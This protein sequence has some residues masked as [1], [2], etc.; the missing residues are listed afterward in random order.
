MLAMLLIDY[1]EEPITP[2]LTD[3]DLADVADLPYDAE[4][5]QRNDLLQLCFHYAIGHVLRDCLGEQ[6]M[7]RPRRATLH[8]TSSPCEEGKRKGSTA[9]RSPAPTE[10]DLFSSLMSAAQVLVFCWQTC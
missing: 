4:Q 9:E 7:E 1:A 8:W 6:A 3:Q 10:G 2:V 5:N